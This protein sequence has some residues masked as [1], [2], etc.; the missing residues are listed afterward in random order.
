MSRTDI[1]IS[2]Q[3]IVV[4]DSTENHAKFLR[5]PKHLSERLGHQPMKFELLTDEVTRSS[6]CILLPISQDVLRDQEAVNLITSFY[7][8]KNF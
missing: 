6:S 4:R 5:A 8:L 1:R 7:E 2:N 3:S